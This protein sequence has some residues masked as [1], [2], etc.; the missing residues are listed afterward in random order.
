MSE[1][2][3]NQAYQRIKEKM[4]KED[5][6]QEEQLT[7]RECW[8]AGLHARGHEIKEIADHLCLSEQTIITHQ[9]NIYEKLRIHKKTELVSW[10]FTKLINVNGR[11][12]QHL[13]TKRNENQATGI[14]TAEFQGSQGADLLIQ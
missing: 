13:K 11:D 3:A 8:I 6:L 2:L 7:A 10:Y 5:L 1:I 12:E 9:K 14:E 4:H